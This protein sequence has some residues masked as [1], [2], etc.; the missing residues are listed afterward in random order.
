MNTP[1]FPSEVLT[2]GVSC[3]WERDREAREAMRQFKD[4]ARRCHELRTR[5]GFEK[6]MALKGLRKSEE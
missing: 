2:L 3:S 6:I 1:A 4:E 5:K